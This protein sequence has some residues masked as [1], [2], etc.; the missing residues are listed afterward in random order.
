M[1]RASLLRSAFVLLLLCIA[2]PYALRMWAIRSLYL[3]SAIRNDVKQEIQRL[4]NERGW[5]GSDL[6]LAELTSDHFIVHTRN[7]RRGRDPQGCL[8][9]SLPSHAV[10]PCVVSN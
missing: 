8:R 5:N 7:Y 1:K 2:V 9:V 4:A 6:D 3:S 10:S